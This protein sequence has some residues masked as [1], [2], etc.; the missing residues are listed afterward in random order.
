VVDQIIAPSGGIKKDRLLGLKSLEEVKA[1]LDGD[2]VPY[3]DK[4]IIVDTLTAEPQ[5]VKGMEQL[6]PGEVFISPQGNVFEFN[7]IASKRDAPFRGQLATDFA[8]QE[9]RRAQALDFV[10]TQIVGMRRAAEAS[11][12]YAKGYKPEN[13]DAGIAPVAGAPGAPSEKAAPQANGA[14]AAPPQK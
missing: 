11:I 3:Q 9:L 1:M 4:M 8:E 12:Q 7:R 6:P 10:R 5:A 13:P 2:G 14:P